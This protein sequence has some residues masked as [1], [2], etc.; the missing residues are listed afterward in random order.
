M[1]S[2]RGHQNCHYS[3]ATQNDQAEWLHSRMV[4]LDDHIDDSASFRAGI[5]CDSQN[6]VIMPIATNLQRANF[7]KLLIGAVN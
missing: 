6:D 4:I 1:A 3:L 5:R 7:G 2:G